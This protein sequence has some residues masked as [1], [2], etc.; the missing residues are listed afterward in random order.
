MWGCW[1]QSMI[2]TPMQTLHDVNDDYFG[3]KQFF[4]RS[5]KNN[6]CAHIDSSL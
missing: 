5:C 3:Q 4:E 1:L 6:I 2:A